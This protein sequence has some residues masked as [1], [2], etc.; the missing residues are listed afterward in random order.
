MSESYAYDVVGNLASK[1]D[2]N[3]KTTTYSYDTLNGLLKKTPDSSLNQTPVS[4]TYTATGQ[5]NSMSDA[6]GATNYTVYDN[7]DRLK[8]KM[9]PE[10]TLNYTYDAHGNVLTIN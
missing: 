4:F 8:T 5:R 7:R 2:F 9:T 1:T 3:G 6:S 10:G